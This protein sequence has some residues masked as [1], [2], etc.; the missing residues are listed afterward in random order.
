MTQGF[1][2][3]RGPRWDTVGEPRGTGRV[4]PWTPVYRPN[5]SPTTSSPVRDVGFRFVGLRT[6]AEDL[7]CGPSFPQAAKAD[8]VSAG[9]VGTRPEWLF[10]HRSRKSTRRY[11]T[12][13]RW[14]AQSRPLSPSTPPPR[15]HDAQNWHREPLWLLPRKN[16]HVNVPLPTRPPPSSRLTHNALR[17]RGRRTGRRSPRRS[18]A[19]CVMT[20]EALAVACGGRWRSGP[21]LY[22]TCDSLDRN[23]S[24][25]RTHGTPPAV[26]GP[27][28]TPDRKSRRSPTTPPSTSLPLNVLP[29]PSRPCRSP[30]VFLPLP[31]T[32]ETHGEHR[33]PRGRPSPVFAPRD[34]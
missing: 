12:C 9:C 16:V 19:P 23:R 26:P 13:G 11:M 32:S 34:R 18:R 17:S 29:G 6:R 27:L 21:D 24:G 8:P 15:N 30:C 28:P 31:P 33:P 4:G 2:L 25:P 14:R 20:Y 7:M 10:R 22:T 3:C 5:P 1:G